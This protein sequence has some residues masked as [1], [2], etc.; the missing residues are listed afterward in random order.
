MST[1]EDSIC[2]LLEHSKNELSI[3]EDEKEVLEE[4]R[5]NSSEEHKEVFNNSIDR[6]KEDLED[7][8]EIHK[9]YLKKLL[10][11]D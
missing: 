7:K 8:E 5:D 9:G 2:E 11:I 1:I 4:Y 10:N 3:L 6:L